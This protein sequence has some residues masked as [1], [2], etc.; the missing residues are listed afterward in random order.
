V[1]KLTTFSV[2]AGL[3]IGKALALTCKKAGVFSNAKANITACI[4][5][6]F[7]LNTTQQNSNIT[8]PIKI[9]GKAKPRKAIGQK[10]AGLK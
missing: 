8:L 5:Q 10:S 2:F 3:G 9:I 7:F 4:I 1:L 6:N